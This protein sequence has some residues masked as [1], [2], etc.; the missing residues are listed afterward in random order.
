MKDV[1]AVKCSAEIFITNLYETG[2]ETFLQLY[3]H[4]LQ[5]AKLTG[6]TLFILLSFVIRV[7]VRRNGGMMHV[8]PV[9]ICL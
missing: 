4:E 7:S 6:L 2:I 8:I 5:C 9:D 1:L 3:I